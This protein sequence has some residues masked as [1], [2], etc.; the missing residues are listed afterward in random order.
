MINVRDLIWVLRFP[1]QEVSDWVSLAR[2]SHLD[3]GAVAEVSLYVAGGSC[4]ASHSS[5]QPSAWN[6]GSRK[7]TCRKFTCK[8][9]R[10]PDPCGV[11]CL[12]DERRVE[13]S[14]EGGIVKLNDWI[15]ETVEVQFVTRGKD[16]EPQTITG[17]LESVGDRGLMLYYDDTPRGRVFFYPW[18]RIEQVE[19][20]D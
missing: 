17:R 15:D 6:K 20:L 18:H 16:G 10:S 11:G 3:Y 7:F 1:L 5:I 4:E 14:A 13:K 19:K 2:P 12:E 8:I 9:L